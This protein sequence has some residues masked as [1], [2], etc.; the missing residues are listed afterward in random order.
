MPRCLPMA[1]SQPPF[2]NTLRYSITSIIVKT[3]PVTIRLR[4]SILSISGMAVFRGGAKYG[5]AAP[6]MKEE[7]V[8]ESRIHLPSRRPDAI[9][10]RS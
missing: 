7:G 8:R 2:E 1:R 3:K 4:C 5:K 10:H 9:Y 6:G